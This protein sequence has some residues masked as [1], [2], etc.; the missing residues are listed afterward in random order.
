MTKQCN[1][2]LN[3]IRFLRGTW[4]GCDPQTLLLLYKTL[5]RSKIDYGSNWYY[6]TNKSHRRKLEAVQHE[7][8]R[9]AL[10][11]R[12]TT[13]VNVIHVEAKL[14][15]IM[16]RA[17]YLGAKYLIRILVNRSHPLIEIL[18][19]F[20]QAYE[21]QYLTHRLPTNRDKPLVRSLHTLK[22]YLPY[23]ETLSNFTCNLINYATVLE[24]PDVNDNFNLSSLP[25]STA[26]SIFQDTV[27][28]FYKNHITIFTDG[29][30][31][32]NQP[33]VAAACIIPQY[34]L[35]LSTSPLLP[36][37]LASIYTAEC[38]AVELAIDF[39]SKDP[40]I[41][42]LICTDSLSGSHLKSASFHSNS[43]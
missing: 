13:P 32:S 14:P 33:S 28:K 2:S 9:L 35:T 15:R 7:A 24:K 34:N 43:N 4:W 39:A 1:K 41:S 8:I 40:T 38:L 23:T 31:S 19:D 12:R 25:A 11:C 29:S 17:T 30:K 6:P 18:E 21:I 26:N 27:N 20:C 3:I 37:K 16:N 36:T 22:E 42:Y 5:I 10:D